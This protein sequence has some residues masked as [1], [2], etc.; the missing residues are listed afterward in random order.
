MSNAPLYLH[1]IF[2]FL[3]TVCFSI[4]LNAPKKELVYCGLTGAFGW[5][6]YCIL[7]LLNFNSIFSNFAAS[8]VVG[9][10]SEFLAKKLKKPAI[11]FVIPGIVSLVP[12]LGLYKTMFYLVQGNYDLAFSMGT[13]AV[14]ISGAIAL[15][16]LVNTSISRTIKTLNKSK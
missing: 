14:L 3:A 7:K 9:Q 2:A 5:I 1:F 4:F 11:L 15:G 6:T 8:F 10:I 12:G 16:I 13:D